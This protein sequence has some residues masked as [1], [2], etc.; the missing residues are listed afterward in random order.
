MATKT[1]TTKVDDIDGSP[2]DASFSFTW[3]GY[4]YHIDLSKE[5]A[6]ELKA[7]FNKW[8]SAARRDRGNTRKTPVSRVE[9]EKAAPKEAAKSTSKRGTKAGT[10]P[11]SRRS[12][13]AAKKEGPAASE[14]R[15]WAIAQ[16][17]PVPARGR[18][19]PATIQQFMEAMSAA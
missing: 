18:L 3:Q 5:H 4:K 13:P 11:A 6:A 9:T 7:D 15:A 1:I 17:I 8:S 14:I 10:K 16:G 2:A 19:A 12:R